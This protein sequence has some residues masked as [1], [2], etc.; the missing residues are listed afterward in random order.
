MKDFAFA[1]TEVLLFIR[2]ISYWFH[3]NTLNHAINLKLPAINLAENLLS[4]P[5]ILR[6]KQIPVNTVISF[7]LY[8]GL[9]A[10]KTENDKLS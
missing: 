9:G 6:K 3:G 5:D 2:R 8:Y 4:H 1:L 7:S 10:M